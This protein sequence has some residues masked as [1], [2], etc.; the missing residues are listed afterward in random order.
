MVGGLAGGAVVGGAAAT[1]R[2]VRQPLTLASSRSS[3][4]AGPHH[5]TPARAVLNLTLPGDRLHAYSP[6]IAPLNGFFDVIVHGSPHGVVRAPRN[7]ATS[8]SH[9][10]LA[11]MV[12][13][14]PHYRSGTR[15]RLLSCSTGAE[16][17]SFVHHL[18]N[19]LGVEVLAPTKTLWVYRNGR[20]VVADRG[21]GPMSRPTG[22]PD[23]K[24]LGHWRTVQ[25]GTDPRRW[26]W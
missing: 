17:A 2:G 26:R 4:S 3:A 13:S 25:P 1:V 5:P 14:H 21:L 18:S 12:R 6:K 20:L 11:K 23:F 9:R 19:K 15:V 22:Y 16:R 7:P 10:E 24:R 8:I